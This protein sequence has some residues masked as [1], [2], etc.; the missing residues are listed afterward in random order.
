M[1]NLKPLFSG[2]ALAMQPSA[3][4]KMAKLAFQPGM[5][6]FAAGAPNADTFPVTEIGEIASFVLARE[7]KATLQYGLTLGFSGL[8]DAVIEFCSA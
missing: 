7:G 3:I 6:S 1:V 2:D 8:I 4:R 5:I